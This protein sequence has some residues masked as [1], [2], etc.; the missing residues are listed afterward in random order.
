MMRDSRV[1]P[2]TAALVVFR[3]KT[4]WW[5]T[6]LSITAKLEVV[7]AVGVALRSSPLL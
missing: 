2:L 1:R 4:A 3:L 7:P 6:I 5:F